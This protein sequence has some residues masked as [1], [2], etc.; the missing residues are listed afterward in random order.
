MMAT[1]K[2]REKHFLKT[3][4]L[5][6]LPV[7][8]LQYAV[9]M[10]SQCSRLYQDTL[11]NSARVYSRW[12]SALRKKKQI[13]FRKEL[14]HPDLGILIVKANVI[15]F[16]RYAGTSCPSSEWWWRC[17]SHLERCFLWSPAGP[18]EC[19]KPRRRTRC[20]CRLERTAR[21]DPLR[22]LPV[23]LRSSN[24]AG[25]GKEISN[26]RSPSTSISRLST[27]CPIMLCQICG[28][29]ATRLVVE[30]HTDAFPSHRETFIA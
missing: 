29:R 9:L 6:G 30:L 22:G 2:K 25:S 26:R 24:I 4:K 11:I 8:C 13:F 28:T 1:K 15:T 10:E 27:P 14:K 21:S 18:L 19:T 16:Y 3:L 12:L 20:G 23:W 7:W 5:I 17:S